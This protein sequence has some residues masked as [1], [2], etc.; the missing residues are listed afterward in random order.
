MNIVKRNLIVAQRFDSDI[1]DE[2]NKFCS[3]MPACYS[4]D[5]D[6]VLS[7]SPEIFGENSSVSKNTFHV[8]IEDEELIAL[9][10][11]EIFGFLDFI[12]NCGGLLGLFMGVSVLSIIELV[13]YFTIKL[14]MKVVRGK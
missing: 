14:V 8:F 1:A 6:V 9:E 12:G 13:Y 11:S 3:C 5:Y 4:V 10:R 2:N 7:E